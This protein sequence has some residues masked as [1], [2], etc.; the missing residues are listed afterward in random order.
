MNF[1]ERSCL[2]VIGAGQILAE[3]ESSAHVALVV[4]P[5]GDVVVR[6]RCSGDG[7]DG[8]GRPRLKR[9]QRFLEASIAVTKTDLLVKPEA[10]T[11]IDGTIS[12]TFP[13]IPSHSLAEMVFAG[14]DP[15]IVVNIL[16]DLVGEMS[17]CV[18]TEDV[19]K[20]TAD[21]I[22]QAHFDRIERRVGIARKDVPLLEKIASRE[23]ITLNGRKLLGFN[24]I[25]K[26]LETTS[27]HR[28]HRSTEAE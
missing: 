21:F 25:L 8:N 23:T 4:K 14:M 10:L 2:R 16:A 20:A 12:M 22:E 11:D 19:N 1:T 7:I 13:Y 28:E 17:S 9:Q 5:N 15:T 18:W 27:H 24:R 26:A 3:S 6:K